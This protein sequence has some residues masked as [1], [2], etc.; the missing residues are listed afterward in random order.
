MAETLHWG[1]LKDRWRG[2]LQILVVAVLVLLAFWF[3][4]A[5][6]AVDPAA[7]AGR[8]DAPSPL[9]RVLKPTASATALRIAITGSVAVRNRVALTPQVGGRVVWLSPAMRT[10]G[11]FGADERLLVID[12]RDFELAY[13]QA[14]AEVA[15]AEADLMLQEAQGEAARANYALLNPDKAVPS[16]IAKE[17]QIAQATARLAAAKAREQIA[18]LELQRTSFSLPFDGR[19]ASSSAEIGQVLSRGQA[20]G[21]AYALDAVQVVAPIAPD[22]LKSLQGAAGRHATVRDAERSLPA[23][24]ERV[25]AELDERSRFA[26]L[27]L[28]YAEGVDP[29][30]PGTFVDIEIEGPRIADTFLLPSAAE[31]ISGSAWVVSAGVLQAVVPETL[32]RTPDGWLVRAFD[33]ADGVVLGAVPGARPA[34]AVQTAPGGDEQ[35]S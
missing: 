33:S 35:G 3:A 12:R 6:D 14:R 29:P 13:D 2:P 22:D 17:P 11:A 26:T 5:P 15:T 20:F 32:G 19:I 23:Q 31:Q 27:Y 9:V 16:L 28:T 8:V 10:G 18:A 25:S 7:G 34:L 4:R 24:V 1:K 21:Q 30:T